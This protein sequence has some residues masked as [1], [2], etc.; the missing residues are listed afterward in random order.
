MPRAGAAAA[1]AADAKFDPVATSMNDELQSGADAAMAEL[2]LSSG[3]SKKDKKS[4]KAKGKEKKDKG[5][6]ASD[7]SGDGDDDGG[8]GA[9]ADRESGIHPG[10]TPYKVGGES[11]DWSKVRTPAAGG[12]VS[13]RRSAKDT[14][15]KRRRAIE[16]E[17]D[18]GDGAA[19]AVGATGGG[20]GGGGGEPS[21][22]KARRGNGKSGGKKSKKSKKGRQ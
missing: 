5:K 19:G 4:K 14:N 15:K 18:S 17:A 12:I 16:G 20:G 3:K 1:L 21:A 11:A 9:A 22:K 8:A 7:E 2:G 13:V 10:L 6:G